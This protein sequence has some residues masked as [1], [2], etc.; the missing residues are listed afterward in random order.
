MF[1]LLYE[2]AA[3]LFTGPRN[4]GCSLLDDWNHGEEPRASDPYVWRLPNP[5]DARW[6]RWA[7]RS[8]AVGNRLPF[9]RVED[10]WHVATLPAAPLWEAADEVVR[11]YVLRR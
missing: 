1:R 9:P 5:H 3:R 10:C 4:N 7:R 11:P 8:H 6:R 2:Y